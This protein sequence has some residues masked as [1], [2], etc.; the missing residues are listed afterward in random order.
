MV[1]YIESSM[2]CYDMEES[3][4]ENVDKLLK[5]SDTQTLDAILQHRQ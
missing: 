4:Q 2:L 3:S 5:D 1:K